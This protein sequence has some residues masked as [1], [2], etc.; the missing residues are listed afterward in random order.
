MA[1]EK[2]LIN[3]EE[4]YRVVLVRS[5]MSREDDEEEMKFELL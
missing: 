2:Y 3:E 1:V 4:L 5:G